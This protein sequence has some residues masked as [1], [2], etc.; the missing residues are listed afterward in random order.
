MCGAMENGHT[1]DFGEA[2]ARLTCLFEDAAGIASEGQRV[3][4]EHA[5]Y[6]EVLVEI[7]QLMARASLIGAELRGV[8]SE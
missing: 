5:I 4:L 2:F 8:L 7:E 3:G 6:E 1:Y